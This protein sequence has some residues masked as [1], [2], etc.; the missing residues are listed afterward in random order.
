MNGKIKEFNIF[1]SFYFQQNNFI[2]KHFLILYK[3][4]I[5]VYSIFFLVYFLIT[6][7]V[8]YV[9]EFPQNKSLIP[10]ESLKEDNI[11]YFIF[12]SMVSSSYFGEIEIIFKRKR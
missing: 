11:R 7:R 3:N 5:F 9:A 10:L 1:F 6:G 2:F 12:K 8:N 4:F